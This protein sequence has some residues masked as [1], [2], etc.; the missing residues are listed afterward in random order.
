MKR[1]FVVGLTGVLA[2]VSSPAVLAGTNEWTSSHAWVA[3]EGCSPVQSI[4]GIHS[5]VVAAT[6]SQY[7][8]TDASEC[9][10]NAISGGYLDLDGPDYLYRVQTQ[11]SGTYGPTNEPCSDLGWH[12]GLYF[13][14]DFSEACEA[15]TQWDFDSGTCLTPFSCLGLQGVEREGFYEAMSIPLS[16]CSG[17]ESNDCAVTATGQNICIDGECFGRYLFSGGPCDGAELPDGAASAASNGTDCISG[18]GMTLCSAKSDKN[19]GTLNGQ[20]IC[21][22]AIPPGQCAF[23]GNGGMVCT[24]DVAGEPGPTD[25]TGTMPAMPDGEFQ[26]AGPGAIEPRD[27]NYYSPAT[28]AASGTDPSGVGNGGQDDFPEEDGPGECSEPGACEGTVPE[29]EPGTDYDETASGAWA[30]IAAAPIVAAVLGL[31][32]TLPEGECPMPEVTLAYLNNQTI[33]LE[34]HCTLWEEWSFILSGVMLAVFVFIG[35]KILMSA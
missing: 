18:S 9:S 32:G 34:Q 26:A 19:C 4:G 21:V 3:A 24:S 8:G 5:C 29:V 7:E 15:G 30:R 1:W 31:G 33:V 13:V 17:G 22:E 12:S 2:L 10:F 20:P 35:A 16:G 27:F 23:L 14:W 6:V 28:V 25:E 11:G